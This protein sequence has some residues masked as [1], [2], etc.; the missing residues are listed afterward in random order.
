MAQLNTYV[1]GDLVT[2]T[3][4][5]TNASG[6]LTNPTS[7]SGS[8]KDPSGT[9]TSPSVSQQSTGVYIMQYTIS[10]PGLHSYRIAGTGAATA[11]GEG[12]FA[13]SSAFF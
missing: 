2:M 6:T 13:A 4:T 7:V 8:V 10:I 11:A 5:F 1:V 3:A 12:Q 9:V